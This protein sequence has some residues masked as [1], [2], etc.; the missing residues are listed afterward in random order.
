MNYHIVNNICD[1]TFFILFVVPPQQLKQFF[2]ILSDLMATLFAKDHTE[3]I[4]DPC[5]D[6]QQACLFKT[7]AMTT[8]IFLK[9]LEERAFI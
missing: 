2:K 7:I 6:L 4:C 8:F 9:T 1:M 3:L 5:V